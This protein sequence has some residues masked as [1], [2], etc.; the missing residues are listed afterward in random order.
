MAG[1]EVRCGSQTEDGKKEGEVRRD[2]SQLPGKQDMQK[3]EITSY[4][5]C[6]KA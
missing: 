3:N 4:E 6:G 2:A 5:L 1:Q